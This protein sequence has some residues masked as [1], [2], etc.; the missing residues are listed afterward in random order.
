MAQSARD[1]TTPDLFAAQLFLDDEWV[2]AHAKLQRVWHQPIKARQPVV[3]PEHPWESR[4]VTMFGTVLRREGRYQMWY[5]AGSHAAPRCVCYA[6]SDDGLS[7]TKPALGLHEVA[8]TTHNNV[9][10]LSEHPT[11]DI[12]DITVIDDPDDRDWPLKALFWDSGPRD[13]PGLPDQGYWAARSRDGTHWEKLGNVLP[14]WGDRFNAMSRRHRGKFVVYGR[15]PDMWNAGGQKGRIVSRTDSD[16]LTGWSAPQIVLM[17]D[18]DDPP[19]MQF[20]SA[21]AFEYE[22]RVLGAIERM[23]FSP[24]VLDVELIHSRD[25]VAWQR[26]QGRPAFLSPG[27]PGTWDDTWVNLSTAAPIRHRQQLWFY[28]AGRSTAHGGLMPAPSGAIG[29]AVLRADGFCSLQAIGTPGYL[30]TRPMTW[31]DGD[32][33]VNAD[34][35]RRTDEYPGFGATCGELRVGVRDESDRPIEGFDGPDCVPV[36]RNTA[37]LIGVDP[38][39]M[40]ARG[41]APVYEAVRWGT[42]RSLRELRGRRIRLRFDLR[43]VHLYSFCAGHAAGDAPPADADAGFVIKR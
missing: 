5:M 30:L 34:T 43:D 32:L 35:R 26:P 16:D 40:T 15:E 8:G 41:K 25:G 28:Y 24:D 18:L 2:A 29:L 21:M 31:P 27:P 10:I 6:C 22:S 17:P 11:G 12:D 7:W 14:G 33:L 36:V 9:V 19:P 39:E 3:R 42:G 38:A 37:N 20:Y 23:H 13:T 4:R 1:R